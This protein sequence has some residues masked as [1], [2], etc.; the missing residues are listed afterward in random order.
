MPSR[1][2]IAVVTSFA[3]LVWAAV[4]VSAEGLPPASIAPTVADGT[5]RTDFK[6]A[7]AEARR[8]GL[9]LLVHFHAEWCGP[10]QRME[11]ET[12][13]TMALRRQVQ[14]RF[15]AVKIDSTHHQ[16]LVQRFKIEGLPSDLVLGNDGTI[17]AR[18]TGY[19]SQ[20]NYLARL[21]DVDARLT[22]ANKI[23]I[24][25]NSIPPK[26]PPA[27]TTPAKNLPKPADRAPV[28]PNGILP[29]F[30]ADDAM[31]VAKPKWALGL[32]GFNPV[33][34]ANQK[35]W[36]KGDKKFSEEYKGIVYHLTSEA[37]RT[38]FRATPEKFA[39]QLLGCDPVILEERDRA[40][41][42]D[43]R[44]GVY[45]DGELFF[46]VNAANRERFKSTPHRYTH[47][48]HVI[49]LKNI[50]ETEVR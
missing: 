28:G 17:L 8:L 12:L 9:P 25:G 39:P 11:R 21:S 30:T 36:V 44:Y 3:S 49:N 18:S 50:Q 22:R 5:W 26:Q 29:D 19:M 7:E 15:V 43:T 14:G 2:W 24:A 38:E 40:V 48:K 33:V 47:T 45:Y 4:A 42:G 35:R 46:F 27:P 16:D 20:Q 10:C 13:S 6:S 41:V 23:H 31:P 32:R 34:L 37:E 1:F